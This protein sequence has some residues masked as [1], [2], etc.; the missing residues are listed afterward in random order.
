M[1]QR[2]LPEYVWE[3]YARADDFDDNFLDEEWEFV[4]DEDDDMPDD[5]IESLPSYDFGT[6]YDDEYDDE[7]WDDESDEWDDHDDDWD[8]DDDEW[9]DEYDDDDE[10]ENW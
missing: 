4:A 1:S 5:E 6:A 9:D 7:D 10:E 2:F 8:D 3:C